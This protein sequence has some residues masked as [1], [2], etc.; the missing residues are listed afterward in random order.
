MWVDLDI[1]GED[2][3]I[4]RIM[5][6]YLENKRFYALRVILSYYLIHFI[7][8]FIGI[9]VFMLWGGFGHVIGHCPNPHQ[10]LHEKC[11][12]LPQQH[13]IYKLPNSQATETFAMK[14]NNTAS[15]STEIFKVK[16]KTNHK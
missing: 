11:P 10:F 2:L 15:P 12:N 13:T 4:I 7:A 5:N 8:L 14:L 1:A 9:M 6:T 3:D 16:S